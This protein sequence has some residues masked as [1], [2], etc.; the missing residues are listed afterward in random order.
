[1][2]QKIS[3]L[4]G[5]DMVEVLSKVEKIWTEKEFCQQTNI[6]RVTA[7]RLR[8]AGLLSFYRI[9]NKIGYGNK[10]IEEFLANCEGK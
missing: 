2:W 4:K 3:A 1:V 7:W 5:V 9:G 10:H 6:S 8:S